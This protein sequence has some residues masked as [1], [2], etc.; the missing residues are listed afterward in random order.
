MKEKIV[1]VNE[2]DKIIG[3]A[4]KLTAHQEGLLHR[5]FSVFVYRLNSECKLELLLQKR[6]MSKY[7]S[8]GLWTNTCCSHP[9]PGEPLNE[10]ALRRL[11][12]EMGLSLPFLTLLG[13]FYYHIQFENGLSE[14]EWDYVFIGQWQGEMISV[15]PEEAQDFRWETLEQIVQDLKVY[16]ERYTFW[17]EQALDFVVKN[18]RDIPQAAIPVLPGKNCFP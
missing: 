10:A 9:M 1:L 13:K 7:H 4:E 16:P 15:N 3:E 14:H 18:Q 11:Q 12:Q 8:G 5:A 2:Q 17:F 6:Q